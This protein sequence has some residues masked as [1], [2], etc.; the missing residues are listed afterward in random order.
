ME[1]DQ[2]LIV[3]LKAE[4]LE[5]DGNEGDLTAS[6]QRYF[7]TSTFSDLTIVTKDQNFQ[8]HKLIICG[9]S[10]SGSD[11]GRISPMLFNVNVYQIRDKYGVPRLKEQAKEKFAVTI[12]ACW[13]MADFPVAIASAYSTTTAADRGL[14]DLVVSTCLEHLIEL[15]ENDGFKQVLS[16]TSA[17]RLIFCRAVVITL[18][19]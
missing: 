19:Q 12:N 15:L 18:A 2:T 16:E 4:T 14:R 11:Q 6:I 13:Q 3:K 1:N 10:G 8:V 7:H 9:Q 17:S 5:A